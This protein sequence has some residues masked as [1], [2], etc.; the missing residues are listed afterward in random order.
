VAGNSNLRHFLQINK[1]NFGIRQGVPSASVDFY[2]NIV[3]VHKTF[4]MKDFCL[5]NTASCLFTHISVTSLVSAATVHGNNFGNR[6]VLTNNRQFVLNCIV[7]DILEQLNDSSS[8]WI[9]ETGD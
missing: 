6:G 8:S 5:E 2:W 3:T 4:S 7:Y 9:F 1:T